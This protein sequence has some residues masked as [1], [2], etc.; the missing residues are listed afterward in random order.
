[1][2]NP[3]A[4]KMRIFLIAC[5]GAEYSRPHLVSR[6]WP[7]LLG[8]DLNL[9]RV[10]TRAKTSLDRLLVRLA[11]LSAI[12]T[13]GNDFFNTHA[14]HC[15]LLIEEDFLS[16]KNSC[17]YLKLFYTQQTSTYICILY[18]TPKTFARFYFVIL[19]VGGGR[20]RERARKVK[21]S[22]IYRR[23]RA[24]ALRYTILKY[25]KERMSR[26]RVR[27]MP[28]PININPFDKTFITPEI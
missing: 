1:M 26:V 7:P 8:S 19:V 23:H 6:S 16:T 2:H 21:T 20:A 4:Q 25:T 18:Y 17:L 24:A 14:L 5:P 15:L 10:T 11:I 13:R 12:S 9:S 3:E 27:A 22:E 28:A